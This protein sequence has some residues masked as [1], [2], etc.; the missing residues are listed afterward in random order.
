MGINTVSPN[1][2]TQQTQQTAPPAPLGA[3]PVKPEGQG[4][5]TGG[6]SDTFAANGGK[7]P[8]Y[9][10]GQ[11]IGT[12]GNGQ[13]VVAGSRDM[14][15]FYCEHALFSSNEFANQPN[16]SIKRD[17]NGDAMVTFIHHPGLQDQE[18]S[19]D[20]QKG[21]QEVI[22]ATMRGYVDAAKGQV[23]GNEPIKVLVTGYG[24]FQGVNN[25]PT[26]DYVTHPQNLDAS[27]S[28]GFGQ[29]LV[30]NQDGTPKRESLPQV[31]GQPVYRYQLQNQD[32]TTRNVDVALA[33]LPVSDEAING[34]PQSVQRLEQDFRPNAVINN[35]VNPNGSAWQ[36][37]THSDDG[38]M[39][40][41]GVMSYDDGNSTRV[42]G[43]EYQNPSGANAF[44][45]GEA[46]MT[47]DRT[48]AGSVP[49]SQLPVTRQISAQ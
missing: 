40:R 15:N 22:G 23:P 46:A 1:Q 41:T 4:S 43:Y 24:A 45:A 14:G 17:G 35:G 33:L 21:A 18:N 16:S 39:R 30:R 31:D 19:P 28:Q 20:R 25:N 44:K 8:Q 9:R 42:R 49:V 5:G 2:R 13:Q 38:G 6:T 26:Q 11:A 3:T 12:T 48:S 47:Q 10:D 32:G 7:P 29:Q 36:M 27:M 34:G 37:E